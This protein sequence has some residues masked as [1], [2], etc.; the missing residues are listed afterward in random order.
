MCNFKKPT[1]DRVIVAY[2]KGYRI[3]D[4]RVFYTK[5][6]NFRKTHVDPSTGYP[7]F[8]FRHDGR[9]FKIKAHKL[10]AYQKYKGKSLQHGL[11][12]RHKDDD[13][14][15]FDTANLVMGSQSQNMADKYRGRKFYV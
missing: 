5:T 2:R 6:G 13:V 9:V 12:V 8:T 14:M 3:V 7:K 1:D 10:G 4:G 11:V 15:N